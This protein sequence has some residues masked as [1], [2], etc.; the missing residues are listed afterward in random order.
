[1]GDSLAVAK[2]PADHLSGL[3]QLLRG[4]RCSD[5]NY[6]SRAEP[7][8]A[9]SI[10]FE[11]RINSGRRGSGGL[12]RGEWRQL[13][14]F[15]IHLGLRAPSITAH[16]VDHDGRR[17]ACS[18]SSRLRATA[19]GSSAPDTGPETK[20]RAGAPFAQ[21]RKSNSRGIDFPSKRICGVSRSSG[22]CSLSVHNSVGLIGAPRHAPEA[23]AD[24][25]G[26]RRTRRRI[27]AGRRLHCPAPG[28]G[29]PQ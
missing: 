9:L 10:F 28:L 5:A 6:P 16:A 15:P 8:S 12:P 29:R 3:P 1:M 17:G 23:R 22:R 11:W 14:V 2:L 21:R 4:A 27:S 7:G 19:D 13:A 18:A 20:G 26:R 24:R 25:C